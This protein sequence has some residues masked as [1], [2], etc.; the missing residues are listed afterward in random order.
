MS[1]KRTSPAAHLLR[2][3]RLFSLPPQL[4]RPR[5]DP[6]GHAGSY[7]NASSATLPHPVQQAI[8]TPV[9]SQARGD[10]GLKR[11][12]PLRS[13]TKT[14]TPFF[15]INAIDTIEH[16]TDYT[17]AGDHAVT[18]QKFR[19]LSMPVTVPGK[20]TFAS[21]GPLAKSVFEPELDHTDPNVA[22]LDPITGLENKR[23][24]FKGPYLASMNAGEFSSYVQKIL[25]S[26]KSEFLA[27]AR[28]RYAQTINQDKAQHARHEGNELPKDATSANITDDGF[29]AWLHALRADYT[30]GSNLA[31]LVND[32]LDMP[33]QISGNH[34]A[35]F[36][37]SIDRAPPTTHPSAGLS[38]LRS[39]A[40]LANHPLFGPQARPAPVE[41]RVLSSSLIRNNRSQRQGSLGIAGV[42]TEESGYGTRER[43]RRP[44]DGDPDDQFDDKTL[45]KDQTGKTVGVTIQGGNRIWVE[46]VRVVIDERGRINMNV[47]NADKIAIG[48]HTGELVEPATPTTPTSYAA[49][50]FPGQTY[51]SGTPAPRLDQRNRQSQGYGIGSTVA[52]DGMDEM[53]RSIEA[54][55]KRESSTR[56]K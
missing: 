33:G 4:P 46:P 8:A 38:Y 43:V 19:H 24:K 25:K 35:D 27:F 11:P 14:S 28:E 18:L 30:L 44:E 49:P 16:I 2:N 9:P 23:W 13:T 15:R 50:L 21:K 56:R 1:S 10:W 42:V 7:V 3:S 52:S 36:A 47:T 55:T 12:L 41:A 37:Q 31:S 26:R 6:A 20:I 54:S 22:E 51:R 40:F 39:D 17:S 5:N 32:F 48:V 53:V 29:R 45:R 34:I